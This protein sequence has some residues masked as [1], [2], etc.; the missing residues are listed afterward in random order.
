MKTVR[1]SDGR[2]CAAEESP[3]SDRADRI[4][5]RNRFQR[6]A[7]CEQPVGDFGHAVGDR[8]A[9][10]RSA[11]CKSVFSDS[12]QTFGEGDAFERIY[13]FESTVRNFHYALGK[14]D[15]PHRRLRFII[16]LLPVERVG[17][18]PH[19][20]R[21]N[22]VLLCAVVSEEHAVADDDEFVGQRR[23]IQ[24]VRKCVRFNPPDAARDPNVSKPGFA[25]CAFP[26]FRNAVRQLDGMHRAAAA[27]GVIVYAL[28]PASK[29]D[30]FQRVAVGKRVV[31]D[32]PHA[33]GKR[34]RTERVVVVKSIGADF[35]HGN[36][37]QRVGDGDVLFRPEIIGD[38]CLAVAHSEI[39]IALGQ[40]MDFRWD[41]CFR[42][43][44]ALRVG[45]AGVHRSNEQDCQQNQCDAP[46]MLFH[47]NHHAGAA[48]AQIGM[49][50]GAAKFPAFCYNRLER[51]TL[52]STVGGVARNSPVA[53]AV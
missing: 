34:D 30:R 29:A 4:A 27:E 42:L 44:Y 47:R 24:R 5:Q 18:E 39:E 41:A 49:K 37:A 7:V 25:E 15:A 40:Q 48:P 19:A 53:K 21:Q 14:H 22:D 50:T 52:Q 1:Q 3:F 9:F 32:C 11:A 10:Q 38:L 46:H 6:I 45:L 28:Q 17:Y 51:G 23:E 12:A 13:V 43:R 35:R 26:D 2:Q 33:V 16:V 36:A 20:L 31:S 8:N